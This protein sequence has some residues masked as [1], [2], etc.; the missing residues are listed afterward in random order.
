[1]NAVPEP[2]IRPRQDEDL[3]ACATALRG[4]HETDGYPVRWPADPSQWLT[5]KS[6][7]GA[8]IAADGPTVLG[9]VALTQPGDAITEAVGLPAAKLALVARLF[10]ALEARRS[11]IASDLLDCAA[12]AASKAGLQAVLEVDAAAAGAVALYERSGWRFVGNGEGGWL[13]ADGLPARVRFYLAP[14]G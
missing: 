3:P 13:A 11:G 7:L 14:I 6:M 1:L 2:V 5:P 8:W 12:R 9:H 10:V 4:V